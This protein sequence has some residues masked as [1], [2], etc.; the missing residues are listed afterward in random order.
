VLDPDGARA[1]E[2]ALR[3]VFKHAVNMEGATSIST[4]SRSRV[5]MRRVSPPWARHAGG[6]AASLHRASARWRVDTARGGRRRRRVVA[7]G[8]WRRTCSRR[9]GISCRWRQ[10]RLSSAFRRRAPA[11]ASRGRA[12]RMSAMCC[13]DAQGIRLTTGAEFAAR[14]ASRQAGPA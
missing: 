8:P 4:R 1:L 2:P 14:D 3:P 13:A 12:R 7:L 6:D 10:A 5:P 11:A 9:L